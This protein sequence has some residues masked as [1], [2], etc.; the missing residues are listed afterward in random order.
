MK[1]YQESGVGYNLQDSTLSIQTLLHASKHDQQEGYI[2]PKSWQENKEALNKETPFNFVLEP[3]SSVA[4]L[5]S[6]VIKQHGQIVGLN[7]LMSIR[8]RLL[9]TIMHSIKPKQGAISVHSQAIIESL[10][11]STMPPTFC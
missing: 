7:I 1:G 10:I 9:P 2:L 3:I 8:L 4:I 6:P 11:T 5:G